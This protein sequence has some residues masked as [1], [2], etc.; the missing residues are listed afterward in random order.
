M[1]F[2]QILLCVVVLSGVLLANCGGNSG[3]TAPPPGS[4]RSFAMGF[5]P[6]PYD[7]TTT[8]VDF[9]YN[10]IDTQGDI[11]AHHLDGGIPWQE[12]HDNVPYPAA[13]EAELNTRLAK[14]P[15]GE[16]VY[17][18]ISPFNGARNDLADYWSTSTN[19][20]LPPA[21]AVRDF[22]S[23]EVV[24]AYTNFARDLINRFGPDYFN[25]GIE[26]SELA[27]NDPAKFNKFVLFVEQ[28][29]LTLR[30][31]FPTV[32][33]M[34]SVGLKSPSSADA[35]V[36]NTNVPN[37]VQ[38]V[39]LVGASVYP[40]VF[41]DHLDKG[42]P[43]NLPADWLSQLLTI[44]NG[45]PVAVAETGW[46]AERLEIPTF[47]VDI[48]A[49]ASDQNLYLETLFQQ[50]ELMQAEFIIWFSL[51]DY[52]ALWNGVLNQDP[53]AHI[54]RDTGLYDQNLISRPSFDTWQRQLAID[55]AVGPL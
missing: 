12:A 13:V 25:L 6:W 1:K 3:T 54:W 19:Q 28:V 37:L 50:A 33:L 9:V 51:V 34:I 45:K 42:D 20:A 39:D 35:A 55:L 23:P 52:D 29:S 32:K 30:S 38:F 27:I 43:A 40:Y 16:R 8:A 26:A 17:L 36:I 46:I 10:E 44:A 14:T 15:V 18:A 53:I 48:L 31:E 21:W 11:I 41:F 2:R 7:A 5:T 49:N 22:D 24:L 47:G 4:T